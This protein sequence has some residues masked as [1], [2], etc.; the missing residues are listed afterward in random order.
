[1]LVITRDS[2]E[3]L[4]SSPLP[5]AVEAYKSLPQ[6]VDKTQAHVDDLLSFINTKVLKAPGKISFRAWNKQTEAKLTEFKDIMTDSY[7]RLH[8][9]IA[10]ANL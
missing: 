8:T 3:A 9:V 6:F 7:Q 5:A 4:Q 2:I 1:M 10:S